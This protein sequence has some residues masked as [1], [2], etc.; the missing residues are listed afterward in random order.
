MLMRLID[1]K[2]FAV[3]AAVLAGVARCARAAPNPAGDGE[4]TR[5]GDYTIENDPGELASVLNLQAR[6]VAPQH[7]VGCAN[8]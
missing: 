7:G 5:K 6:A 2:L 3:M 1:G 8:V 4:A